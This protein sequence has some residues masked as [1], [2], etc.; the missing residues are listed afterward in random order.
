MIALLLLLLLIHTASI[1]S[2]IVGWM[3]EWNSNNNANIY[4]VFKLSLLDEIL[5]R[6][7]SC[8]FCKYCSFTLWVCYTWD[9]K[10]SISLY[11]PFQYWLATRKTFFCQVDFLHTC[12]CLTDLYWLALSVLPATATNYISFYVVFQRHKSFLLIWVGSYLMGAENRLRIQSN[13]ISCN[14]CA[15]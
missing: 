15:D 4:F 6:I 13:C 7:F 9:C 14:Q 3:D 10:S 1:P 11:C 5:V 2:R 8:L 12:C